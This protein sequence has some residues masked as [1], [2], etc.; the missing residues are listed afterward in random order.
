MPG[1]D[2][3][4]G[5]PGRGFWEKKNREQWPKLIRGRDS[6]QRQC[7]KSWEGALSIG[8]SHVSW[9]GRFMARQRNVQEAKWLEAM[10]SGHGEEVCAGKMSASGSYMAGEQ[11]ERVWPGLSVLHPGSA[12]AQ[13]GGSNCKSLTSLTNGGGT[14]L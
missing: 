7:G 13:A 9:G 2:I 1:G 11:Q 4:Q 10:G 3:R 6:A 5:R 12:R 8:S 14:H